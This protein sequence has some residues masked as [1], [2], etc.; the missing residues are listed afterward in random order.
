MRLQK[1]W[2][3]EISM[4]YANKQIQIYSLLTTAQKGQKK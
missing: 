3:A 4:I 1:L 2:L